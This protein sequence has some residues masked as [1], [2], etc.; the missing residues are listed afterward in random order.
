LPLLFFS[1]LLGTIPAVLYTIAMEFWFQSGLSARCEFRYAVTI[2]LSTCLGAGAGFLSGALGFW[3]G[4]TKSDRLYL[5]LIGGF[6]GLL[7]GSYSGRSR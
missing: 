6:V 2:G 1:Y 3:A 4:F 7:V 5:L